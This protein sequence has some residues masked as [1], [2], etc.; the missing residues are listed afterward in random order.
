[1][2]RARLEAYTADTDGGLERRSAVNGR[3]D[4]DR[5]RT[6]SA[7]RS[8]ALSGRVVTYT[9]IRLGGFQST[10]VGESA[11]SGVVFERGA[12]GGTYVVDVDG[13]SPG[14]EGLSV[15]FL[16]SFDRDTERGRVGEE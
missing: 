10:A 9:W 5:Q 15:T 8:L 12:R 1:M 14:G 13:L 3:V 7:G 4:C 6:G 16:E 11:C 2:A